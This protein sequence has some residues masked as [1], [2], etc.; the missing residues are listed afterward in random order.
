MATIFSNSISSRMTAF[1]FLHSVTPKQFFI[2]FYYCFA[3]CVLFFEIQSRFFL[4]FS[5]IRVRSPLEPLARFQMRFLISR[6]LSCFKFN[7]F[8]ISFQLSHSLH[9]ERTF[10]TRC[11]PIGKEISQL[12]LCRQIALSHES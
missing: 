5:F 9:T 6:F 2:L 1:Y 10:S 8:L 12:D 7:L 3:R 11:D 4:S